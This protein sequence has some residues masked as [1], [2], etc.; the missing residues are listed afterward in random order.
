[1]N[2]V[3]KTEERKVES[4]EQQPT[5]DKKVEKEREENDYTEEWTE[6]LMPPWHHVLKEICKKIL[7]EK[8]RSINSKMHTDIQR[9]DSSI[10]R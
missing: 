7:E 2:G 10:Q 8:E 4:A 3:Q 5:G 9:T 1:L 6:S